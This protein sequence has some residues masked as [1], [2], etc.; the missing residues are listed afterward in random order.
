VGS[1][2]L[3]APAPAGNGSTRGDQTT[4]GTSLR[5][6]HAPLN[7]GGM[8]GTLAA[9][10]RRL[11]HHAVSYSVARHDFG[12][13][14]DLVEPRPNSRS[15]LTKLV[16][17]FADSFDVFHFYF[18]ESI[19][20]TSLAD[21]P[22]LAK[23]KKKIFFWFC[24]CE[25]RDEKTSLLA[26]EYSACL[27]CFPK[28][29]LN[30]ERSTAVALAYATALFVATPDLLEFVPGSILLPQVVDFDL[31]ESV[32]IPRVTHDWSR[33]FRIVHA[34]SDRAIKGTRY[35][36]AAVEALRHD[37]IEVEL[38]L[39]ERLNHAEVLRR[40]QTADLA[41][42]QVLAGSYGI[43]AAEMMALGIPVVAYIRSDL[44]SCY[45]APPPVLNANPAN[46]VDVLRAAM[47]EP[48]QR[49]KL[50]R[51]GFDYARQVHHPDVIAKRTL[52]Y[53]RG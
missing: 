1:R 27:D 2:E 33:P 4:L 40:A 18:G 34:P 39:L 51:D 35:I 52:A 37:G 21:V 41:I 38:E 36:E 32:R 15:G 46:L 22:M 8:A 25:V 23:M 20:G 42:D 44:K 12:F 24:G 43:F 7:I 49:A 19:S 53:Y 13:A 30:R 6:L 17:R 45:P 48:D 5:I 10:Q 47:L 28:L 11:G 26:Y 16:R 14:E 9:A 29:C 31:V 50:A 3:A